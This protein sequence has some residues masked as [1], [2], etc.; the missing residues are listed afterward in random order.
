MKNMFD[1]DTLGESFA[2]KLRQFY[3]NN[4][5]SASKLTD[6]EFDTRINTLFETISKMKMGGISKLSDIQDAKS[7]I[8]NPNLSSLDSENFRDLLSKDNLPVNKL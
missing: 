4:G 5:N 1:I 7:F 8:F 2:Y 6:D 3:Q